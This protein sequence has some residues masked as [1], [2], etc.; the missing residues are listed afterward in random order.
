MTELRTNPSVARGAGGV[1]VL[2]AALV[3]AALFPPF[4]S[5]GCPGCSA[6][7]AAQVLYSET[8]LRASPDAWAVVWIVTVLGATAVLFLAGIAPRLMA[9]VNGAA[10]LAALGLSVFEGVVAFPRVVS[11]AVLTPA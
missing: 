4:V 11:T 7:S 1:G 5:Q 10:S 8:A 9:V 6:A 3:L 2:A